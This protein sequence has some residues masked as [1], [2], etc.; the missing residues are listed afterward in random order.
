MKNPAS[1]NT[2]FHISSLSQ[3]NGNSLLKTLIQAQ[4]S[5]EKVPIEPT[6]YINL[7]FRQ[8]PFNDPSYLLRL[9]A[10]QKEDFTQI[11]KTKTRFYKFGSNINVTKEIM[12]YIG[13]RDGTPYFCKLNDF[14]IIQPRNIKFYGGL[15]K[16]ITGSFIE[17]MKRVGWIIL[18]GDKWGFLLDLESLEEP[19]TK[20]TLPGYWQRL[21]RTE[22]FLKKLKKAERERAISM[23]DNKDY[24]ERETSASDTLCPIA[25]KLMVHQREDINWMHNLEREH[26][27]E[28]KEKAKGMPFF[29]T[30]Y[31]FTKDLS[32]L[33]K[34]YTIK[35]QIQIP[36]GILKSQTGSGKTA[37]IIGLIT[38]NNNQPS[39]VITTEYTLFQWRQEFEK[40]APHIRVL[41]VS[42]HADLENLCFSK[43]DHENY[44]LADYDVILTHRRIIETN[45]LIQEIF[46]KVNFQ[47]II[48]DEIHEILFQYNKKRDSTKKIK[49]ASQQNQENEMNEIPNIFDFF[50]TIKKLR[51]NFIWGISASCSVNEIN[52]AFNSLINLDTSSYSLLIK[53][54]IK[55]H[56][57]ERH[58][59]I[60]STK[61]TSP[62][63]IKSVIKTEPYQI[64]SLYLNTITQCLPNLHNAKRIGKRQLLE[65]KNLEN[66]PDS[67][68]TALEMIQDKQ[69]NELNKLRIEIMQADAPN[70]HT[71]ALE[72]RI[73]SLQGQN[74]FYVEATKLLLESQ[75]EC[76][77][78]LAE[79]PTEKVVVINCLHQLCE[80]CYKQLP[81]INPEPKCPICKEL[82]EDKDVIMHPRY[83]GEKQNK[84]N[85]IIK[86][87]QAVPAEEKIVIFIQ[88]HALLEVIA[89]SLK[90]LN[91]PALV[92]KGDC[93][94]IAKTLEKF[95]EG[96]KAKVL[97]LSTEQ[98]ASG[99]DLPEVNHIFFAHPFFESERK[100]AILQYSQCV[101]R[102]LRMGQEKKVNV[103]LFVTQSTEVQA[104]NIFNDSWN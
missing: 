89:K 36:G 8:S 43:I 1:A 100:K 13:H 12:V 21:V 2:G 47:R 77:V 42:E 35:G 61:I 19:A 88:Y 97:L 11:N 26:S 80:H 25:E 52:P 68:A 69:L 29:D 98:G 79:L 83:R 59:R 86:E 85:R 90:E 14:N 39:L 3:P 76:P 44:R 102:V 51:K 94:E 78:C 55:T 46:F 41:V 73:Q 20:G 95:K 66:E 104:A 72:R 92:L 99:I 56:F 87:I 67:I 10:Y 103:K 65:F 48:F 53:N 5:P 84:L 31:C 93:K 24:P 96:T 64:Q 101:G 18:E 63:L 62:D 16:L 27:F 71:K 40:F 6:N 57:L 50:Q 75:F 30:G 54:D 49:P 33:A 37:S 22:F 74:N 4:I 81:K 23:I 91:V 32:R 45:I 58:I 17:D 34:E 7:Y 82:S 15:Q 28:I 9:F 38:M 60:N 70:D